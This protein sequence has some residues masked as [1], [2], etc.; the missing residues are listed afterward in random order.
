[1]MMG[2][3]FPAIF[4]GLLV[5]LAV[6]FVQRRE[7]LDLT[8]RGLLRGYLY[9]AS[10]AGIVTFAIGLGSLTNYGLASAFGTPAIY[11]GAPGPV[12]TMRAACPPGDPRCVPPT[13]EQLELQRRSAKEQTDRRQSEDL[14]RGITF[15]VFG[16]LVW[17]AHW[18]A[19][20]GL[21]VDEAGS[22]M[23]RAYFM[24]GTVTFGLVTVVM[25]PTG[26]YQALSTGILLAD[27]FTYRQPAD[28][29]GG[30]LAALP[31]WLVFLRLLV[32]DVRRSPTPA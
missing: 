18:A 2:I 24:L 14:L 8:P 20:R 23:R 4:L 5:A 17:G 6:V 13:E 11:G 27:Q 21:G 22:G 26:A 15:T 28:S 7:A 9:L 10:L 32:N 31:I 25:L 1:M 30:G 12:I 29:L 3:L 19:R 16:A